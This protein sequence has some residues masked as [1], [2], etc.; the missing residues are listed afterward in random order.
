MKKVDG[1]RLLVYVFMLL[2]VGAV[3]LQNADSIGR[4]LASAMLPSDSRAE[5]S[6]P[7]EAESTPVRAA[8]A[9]ESVLYSDNQINF[10]RLTPLAPEMIDAET[11]WLARCIFSETKRVREQELI[12]WIVRNRVETSYRGRGT[13][14]SVVM[15]PFQFSAFNPG[16]RT[17]Q[18]YTNLGP[19][20]RVPGWQTALRI[21]YE[22]RHADEKFRPF[23]AGTRHFYSEQSMVGPEHPDWALGL[24][25]VLPE[26]DYHV[27]PHRF[28][29][30]EGVN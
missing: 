15:D 12:A 9:T 2:A 25:P 14:Q 8:A 16:S 1:S 3:S 28:R 20:S 27:E 17:R 11:L 30:F 29:F 19:N 21:A 13:Y 7:E 23:S 4:T 6:A 10:R 24:R 5:P 18:Y 26:R 22:V